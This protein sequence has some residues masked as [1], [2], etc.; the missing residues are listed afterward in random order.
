MQHGFIKV[1][2][3]IPP[4]RVADCAFNIQQI[5][6]MMAMADGQGAEII[7][8]PELCVTARTCFSNSSCWTRR[9]LLC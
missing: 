7:C 6:N 8:L 2:A 3:G 9:R 5:E 4:V 1:A